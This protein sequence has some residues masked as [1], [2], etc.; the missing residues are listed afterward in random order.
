MH[1]HSQ[2]K[3]IFVPRWDGCDLAVC[4]CFKYTMERKNRAF[5][6]QI[7]K[8]EV[9]KKTRVVNGWLFS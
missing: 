3:R 4:L 5:K 6:L 9:Q 2:I 8:K 1:T 7:N